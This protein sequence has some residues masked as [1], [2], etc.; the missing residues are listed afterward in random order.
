MNLTTPIYRTF[1]VDESTAI[2]NIEVDNNLVEIIYQTNTS[3]AY[4]FEASDEFAEILSDLIQSPD[5]LGVSLGRVIY[6]A[7]NNG[8]LVALPEVDL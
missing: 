6:Q 3:K 5:L 1:T 7:I 2:H 4:G 8:E